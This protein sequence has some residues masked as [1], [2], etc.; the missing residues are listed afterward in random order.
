MSI[1]TSIETIFIIIIVFIPGFIFLQLTKN[2]VAYIRQEVDARYFFAVI[3]W[4]GV[5]HLLMSYWSIHIVDFYLGGTLRDH[6]LQTVFWAVVTLLLVPLALGFLGSWLLR[7]SWLDR[8]VLRHVR[9]DYVS[10]TPSAWN[11]VFQRGPAWIRI[12]LKDG[13]IIGGIFEQ[14]SFADNFGERDI[15][16]E[17]IYNLDDNGDFEKEVKDSAGVWVSHDVI[18]HIVYFNGTE[19]GDDGET[20]DKSSD[21]EYSA[22]RNSGLGKAWRSASG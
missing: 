19:K 5:I 7:S 14:Q 13:T 22:N 21:L 12:H 8:A 17:R 16:L 10:R 15:F 1:P 11:Y 6:V 18:S 4:G 2:T 20:S 3:V 9:L